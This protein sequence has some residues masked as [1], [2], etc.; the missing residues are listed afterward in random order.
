MPERLT[1][2]LRV[3]HH[4]VTIDG[5]PIEY[6]ATAG[7]LI[8]TEEVES[9]EAADT[10]E[11]PKARL[12][13][14]AYTRTDLPEDQRARRPITFSFNGGPGS[15]SV[16]MHMGLLGPRRVNMGDVGA[17]EPPPW[18]W[19]EN[20]FSLLDASDLVFIDPVGT[21]YSRAAPGA[22]NREFYQFQKDIESVGDFIRLFCTRNGRWPSPK[23]LIG[24]SYGTTRAAALSGYLQDRHGLFLNGIIFVSTIL[25][26]QTTRFDPG[27]DL[28]YALYLPSFAA[29]AWYHGR[30]AAGREL[31]LADTVDA[32]RTFALGDYASALMRGTLLSEAEE[33]AIAAEI[34][35][36]IGIPTE[37]VRRCNL[38]VDLNTFV[39]ELLRDAGKVVGRLDARFTGY[40]L[41]PTGKKINLEPSSLAYNGP[42]TAVLYDYLQR[43]LGYE[44]DLAYEIMN[45]KINADWH[46][47]E[48]EGT[49]VDVSE[50]L[51]RIMC[52]NPHLRVLVCNGYYDLATPFAAAEYT[53]NHLYLPPDLRDHVRMTYYESGHLMYVHLP[54]LAQQKQDLAAFINTGATSL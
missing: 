21:G 10:R 9:P 30:T 6:S 53:F 1:D 43:E 50:T 31:S 17:L 16:W 33:A 13:F 40:D 3:T 18:Q 11:Q 52:S 22:T 15:S 2:D 4:S 19:E 14:V 26:F 28:P 35:R 46:F 48:F 41:G 29:V 32:A 5:Q 44:S 47:G 39:N 54:S 23:Y 12:F 27:N 25:N 37:L 24:E 8:L 51:R 49:Y 34:T 42:Y 7:T 20:P 45:M 38:R 36:F